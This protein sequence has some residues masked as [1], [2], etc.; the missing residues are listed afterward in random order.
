MVGKVDW[1]KLLEKLGG[2]NSRASECLSKIISHII[3]CGLS[4]Q[5]T[6]EETGY[7]DLLIRNIAYQK[8]HFQLMP[9][10]DNRLELN[11]KDENTG[12]VRCFFP[13]PSHSDSLNRVSQIL[14]NIDWTNPV[15]PNKWYDWPFFYPMVK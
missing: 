6:V 5:L 15:K 7:G 11:F 3:D 4:N 1:E 13:H 8:K 12:V 9:I 2:E 10:S 14:S